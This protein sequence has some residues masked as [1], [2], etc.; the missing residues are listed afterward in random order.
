MAVIQIV[1]GGS[2]LDV[3]HETP[4]GVLNGINTDF[5]TAS[6]FDPTTLSVSYNGQ[7]QKQGSGEDFTVHESGGIGTGHDTIRFVRPK[8]PRSGDE[9]LVSYKFA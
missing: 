2:G 8:L 7:L 5:T 6:D 9:I 4:S 1:D 3:W